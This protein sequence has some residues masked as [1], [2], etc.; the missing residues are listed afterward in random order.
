MVA[1]GDGVNPDNIYR[2]WQHGLDQTQIKHFNVRFKQLWPVSQYRGKSL[3]SKTY[4][5]L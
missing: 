5:M 2:V 4:S 3:V 1:H